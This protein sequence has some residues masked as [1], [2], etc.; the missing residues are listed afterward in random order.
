MRDIVEDDNFFVKRNKTHRLLKNKNTNKSFG[1]NFKEIPYDSS[2]DY[3][4]GYAKCLFLY[5][6]N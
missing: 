4:L 2:L 6:N 5:E 3:V 1:I